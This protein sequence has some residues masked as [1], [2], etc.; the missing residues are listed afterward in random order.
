MNF[1]KSRYNLDNLEYIFFK[2]LPDDGRYLILRCIFLYNYFQGYQKR[3]NNQNHLFDNE[4][5]SQKAKQVNL[6]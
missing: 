2:N 6:T 1:L 5:K 4:Q 3:H